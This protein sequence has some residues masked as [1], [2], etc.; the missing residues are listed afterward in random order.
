M[1]PQ[2]FD[3][4]A[5]LQASWDFLQ[6]HGN[7]SGSS[8][9][10]LMH[11]ELTRPAGAVPSSHVVCIGIGPGL[12]LEVRCLDASPCKL[13]VSATK[14]SSTVCGHVFLDLPPFIITH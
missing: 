7:T 10:A 4:V 5:G 12:S 13:V 11:V 1:P 8:N 9:L 14:T 2:D 6:N 3:V